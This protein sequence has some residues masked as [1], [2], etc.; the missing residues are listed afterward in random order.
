MKK[1]IFT[2]LLA[3]FSILT[4][5]QIE[6]KVSN[7]LRSAISN[8]TNPN[9]KYRIII[10][11]ND[12]Y[13][14]VQMTRQTQY[15][16]KAEKRTYVMNELQSFSSASQQN[17]LN[18]LNQ[19]SR[20]G[21]VDDI[22]SFWL[23]NGITCEATSSVINEVAMDKDVNGIYLDHYAY[24]LP[25]DWDPEEGATEPIRGN[26]WNV[27][28]VNAD[29]V[30]ALGYTGTG[31]LVGLID[32]GVKYT[33]TDLANNM[34]N[35]GS[36]Y[37]NHGYD[38]HNNDN[39]PVDDNGHGTHCAGT[40]S[41]YGTNGTQCGIAK[42]AKIM[43]LKVLGSD[44]SGYLYTSWIAEEFAVSHGCD[45]LS[46]SL[47]SDG[48]GP[49]FIERD[50]LVNVMNCG[51][52][53]SIAAG[54]VGDDLTTYPVPGNV[55]SPGNCPAPWGNP[56]QTNVLDGGRSACVTVGATTS[57]D[58]YSSF[59]SIG[60]VTWAEGDDRGDYSD[61]P[62]TKNSTTQ[63]GLIKPD[64]A[65]PGSNI[66]S[67]NYSGTTGYSTKSG[68]SMAT[69]CVAGVM[70][71]LLEVDPTLT[72]VEIDSILET[73]A[74]H[75]GGYTSKN[76]K[77]G[78][79]RVDALAAV[80]AILN[81]C[82][83]PASLNGTVDGCTV[84]LSW[85]AVSGISTYRVY[86]NGMVIASSVSGTSYSDSEAPA[87]HN[88]YYVRSNCSNGSTSESSNIVNVD[89]EVNAQID[90]PSNL[91][92]TPNGTEVSL[93][94][95]APTMR[96]A[97]LAYTTTSSD[98]D[99]GDS[100]TVFYFAQRY[101]RAMLT[102]Y[103][104][105]QINKVYFLPGETG[106]T[107]TVKIHKGDEMLPGEVIYST[108][109]TPSATTMQEITLS[110][111]LVID[112]T[113]DYWLVISATGTMGYDDALGCTDGFYYTY[114]DYEFYLYV[115][116][117]AWTMY[118]AIADAPYTYDV[119]RD[120]Q[121]RSSQKIA[122]GLTGTSYTDHLFQAGSYEYTVTTV[123]NG[124]ESKPSNSIQVEPGDIPQNNITYVNVE[125]GY[126]S[127]PA[128]AAPGQ[129][130][131]LTATPSSG[132]KL[133][134]WNV[135]KTANPA[136]TV[137][138]TNNQFVMPDYD[139]TVSANF[140]EHV[141][142]S[143]LIACGIEHGTISTNY[144]SAEAGTIVTVTATPD[145]GCHLRS[146]IIFN[147]ANPDETVTF[148]TS[149]M[150]FSMPDYDVT[151]SATFDYPTQTTTYQYEKVTSAPSNWAGEYLIVYT[152]G[153]KA[154]NGSL[155][156][157]DANNNCISVTISNN[158]IAS[159][160]NVDAATFTIAQASG[161][162]YTIKSKSGYYIGATSN[163]SNTLLS[164]T[165][166][167]YTN[168]LAYN[169]GNIDIKGS[170][171]AYLR[172]NTQN[173]RFR[174]YRSSQYT[175]QQAIQLYKKVAV[176]TTV[177]IDGPSLTVSPC[178]L[179]GLDYTYDEG[180]SESQAVTIIPANLDNNITVTAPSHY[181]VSRTLD[182]TY[183]AS[184]TIPTVNSQAEPTV[185]SFETG[186]EGWTTI[187]ADGDG[188]NWARASVLMSGYSIPSHE[189]S[190]A[191][192]SQSYDRTAGA[193]TPDNYI[194]SPQVN[195]SSIATLTFWACSQD[196]S[197]PAEHFGVAISTSGNTNASDFTTI[198][199]WTLTAKSGGNG[200]GAWASRDDKGNRE[201]GSWYQ[202]EV[203]LS[204]YSGMGYIAI[205]HF[206]CS[207]QFYLNVDDI[208]FYPTTSSSSNVYQV[209][210]RLK[211]G[212][213][214]GTYNNEMMTLTSGSCSTNVTLNGQ[215]A[216]GIHYT[217]TVNADP[218]EGGSV[219]G[220][221]SYTQ[222]H[223][224][225]VEAQANTGYV[226]DSWKENDLT[227]STSETYTFTAT[228]DRSLTAHFT[229]LTLRNITYTT[230]EHGSITGPATS[231]PGDI[232]TLSILI[233]DEYA[234]ESINIYKT[235]D[236]TTTIELADNSFVMPDYD[237][238]VTANIVY[239]PSHDISFICTNHGT[240]TTNVNR[241]QAGT[242]ISLTATPNSGYIL[243]SY[244]VYKADDI[245]TTIP[246][247][248]E[249]FTMPGYD[250]IVA[251]FFSTQSGAAGLASSTCTIEGFTYAEGNG[252][253]AAQSFTAF[254]ASISGNVTVTAP[255]SYEVCAT[256]NGTYAN[257][258][259]LAAN[260]GS[261]VSNV[262]VRLKA[263]LVEG[264]YNETLQFTSGTATQSV[265]LEGI[266][267]EAT[268]APWSPEGNE[269]EI[270]MTL[271]GIIQ[272]NGVE[273]ARTTLEVGAFCGEECRGTQRAMLAPTG[274]YLV[275]M[276]IHGEANDEISF[277]LFDHI[278]ETVLD[279]LS[280]ASI[281][282]NEDGYGTL[283][284]PYILNFQAPYTFIGSDN[285]HEWGNISNWEG[286]AL[287]GEND[288]VIIEGE[289]E[290]TTDIEVAKLV[291]DENSTIVITDG[292]TLTAGE[293]ITTEPSQL[294]IEDC[295]QL[296]CNSEGVQATF[297]KIIEKNT[298]ATDGWYTIASPINEPT[299]DHVT[300]NIYDIYT[301]D[302]DN[303][304]KEWQ[305]YRV[306][307]FQ[308]TS[309]KGYLYANSAAT[310]EDNTDLIFKGAL[311][312][313]NAVV[314]INLSYNAVYDGIRGFNFLG[315]PYPHN[316]SLS[317]LQGSAGL[318][319]DCYYKIVNG[320]ELV[321]YTDGVIKPGEGFF[322]KA[323]AAGQSVI[324]GEE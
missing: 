87:G 97:N 285:N 178:E 201:S 271:I 50:I 257:S 289:C 235:D 175:G 117:I 284:S 281:T 166:N 167:A 94:W 53:A 96:S 24:R 174:Y 116:D 149:T 168:T 282:I 11:M 142:A 181:E 44:G 266:V 170:G 43:A 247:T 83:A 273:Q 110:S 37:P 189:G 197:Y 148:N 85:N 272:I 100:E 8:Q 241:A 2:L 219:T 121:L 262:Y 199:Q 81:A 294:I 225:T 75:L 291:V 64:V 193:L 172:F 131:T 252:P 156:T 27:T 307:E 279:Y 220:G 69:P 228:A 67:L 293:I 63:I 212:L 55:G 129:T 309:G 61:Y 22:H 46:M 320:T 215:V 56:D 275:P 145:Q 134:S 255:A 169:N 301:Y 73:T 4:W 30:W 90:S 321:R 314:E 177:N 32:T 38:F 18:L 57:T 12:R 154:F 324:I 9:E 323:T 51:V 153:S 233:D 267:T 126:I 206:N 237:V 182:G 42:N 21:N 31:V 244:L 302:E 221:G 231:Y 259:N 274:K 66:V 141:G 72:P 277:K 62:Y 48:L 29:D 118:M 120:S 1:A 190:D 59:S 287:P 227:V 210:T 203:D 298:D 14:D 70:A 74:T 158:V 234:V 312:P 306:S 82:N 124:Y 254:G 160:S 137:N 200:N 106:I 202:F 229:A 316:I 318:T 305:N 258:I 93:S 184:L 311:T 113:Q 198:Q 28:K 194:V 297:H 209:F 84:N 260:N 111:P 138:V 211:A 239:S 35:G 191:V 159:T 91:T 180:P 322:I 71:L 292:N 283:T 310:G 135:Y 143:I 216:S 249:M 171:G 308:F 95:T 136:V 132:Y 243:S 290:V 147:S 79:G 39:N 80:N 99:G 304:Q 34:W 164:S 204:A 270:S 78:A 245:N 25:E 150:T 86:R 295:G 303:D 128:Q 250:V 183:T 186:L 104:G 173:S 224:V 47:G 157:L 146:V 49:Y 226:F 10:T 45:I 313:G 130:V 123:S 139:V 13:D 246:V 232:V 179:N 103:A 251:G 242:T 195:L 60:P 263:G 238:T 163:N 222:G 41:S 264:T 230:T 58:G 6:T 280:P 33:H 205:R 105:M 208:T 26:G 269:Y 68:T 36:E 40:I 101:P 256:E 77:F 76:N 296:Y 207:D 240:V 268:S 109:K 119:Y 133:G 125:N 253:S 196:A 300:A 276:T 89:I 102:Q 187:D 122:E 236:I 65:A 115:N 152:N 317:D 161:S 7:D 265:D 127:G 140:I 114:G 315:N 213:S 108:T 218:V 155:N 52:V 20:G 151:I 188:F 3:S 248:D 214:E 19:G 185:Y 299:V 176:Q 165:T 54:N 17:V 5:G 144:D 112:P 288:Y 319:I 15:M 261:L 107:Y 23:F 223:S 92:A 278:T 217:I 16:T 286:G 162:N 192:S 88:S 98:T